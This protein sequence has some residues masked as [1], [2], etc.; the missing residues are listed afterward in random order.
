MPLVA[1]RLQHLLGALD[2]LDKLGALAA[3]G[4][5]DCGVAIGVLMVDEVANHRIRFAAASSPAKPDTSAI[6]HGNGSGCLGG[7]RR[8][9]TGHDADENPQ[10]CL[11]VD[12]RKGFH[13]GWQFAALTHLTPPSAKAPE[14]PARPCA[15][16]GR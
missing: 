14:Q 2:K 7:M 5:G 1:D 4:H 11:G 13:I 9:G 16:Q 15:R 8:I 12:P 3:K 10:G 6:E